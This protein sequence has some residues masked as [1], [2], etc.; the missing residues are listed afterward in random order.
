MRKNIYVVVYI[1]KESIV[2]ISC[3]L[4]ACIILQCMYQSCTAKVVFSSLFNGVNRVIHT[5]G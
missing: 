4:L 1:I 2:P 3:S 5:E